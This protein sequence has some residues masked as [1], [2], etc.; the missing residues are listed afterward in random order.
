MLM[1]IK[2]CPLEVAAP[3]AAQ[4]RPVDAAAFR[5]AMARLASSVHVITTCLADGSWAGFTATAVCSVSDTPPSLL[6]C[7][8]HRASVYPAFLESENL[9][10]NTL[11]AAQQPLSGLFGGKTPMAERFAAARWSPLETGAPGLD[12][13]LLNFDCRIAARTVAGTHD[14]LVC[15]IV[16]IRSR[17]DGNGL[18]YVDR[19]YHTLPS[20]APLQAVHS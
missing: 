15:H 2:P 9:C 18:V 12:D 5:D 4:V 8:N 1:A 14:I 16:A 3:A 10:V 11:D 17:E 6:V 13:A 20:P 19:R 7:L